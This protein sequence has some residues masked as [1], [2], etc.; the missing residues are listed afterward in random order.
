MAERRVYEINLVVRSPFLFQGTANSRFGVDAT[1]QRATGGSTPIIPATQIRGVLLAALS[2][3]QTDLLALLEKKTLRELFGASSETKAAEGHDL[4]VRGRIAFSDLQA[5]TTPTRSQI[6]RIALDEETGSVETGSLQVIELSH[7]LGM[8]CEFKGTFSIVWPADMPLPDISDIFTKALKLVPAIGALKSAGFGEV[9]VDRSVVR[10]LVERR[11]TLAI[12]A[13]A[14][15]ANPGRRRYRVRFDRPFVVDS[16][17][18]EENLFAGSPIVPGAVFKGALARRLEAMGHS[19][20][21][22]SGLGRAL[23]TAVFSH[24]FPSDTETR[25]TLGLPLPLSLV[26]DLGSGALADLLALEFGQCAPSASIT[27]FAKPAIKAEARKELALPALPAE[28]LAKTDR[29]HVKIDSTNLA[30]EEGKLFTLRMV[31]P[32][33]MLWEMTIDTGNVEDDAAAAL[34]HDAFKLGLDQI[35]RTEAS[36]AIEPAGTETSSASDTMFMLATPAVLFDGTVDLDVPMIER[37]RRY[38][39]AFL[40][41]AVLKNVFASRKLLGGYSATRF[42]SY[43]SAYYP[44][45]ATLPGSVFRLECPTREAA[46]ALNNAYRYG[47]PIPLLGGKKADWQTCPYVPENG[48]GAIVPHPARHLKPPSGMRVMETVDVR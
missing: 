6:T 40:G 15:A 22:S 12:V 46:E 33:G 31:D 48:Y 41:G 39:E 24:S 20:D 19:V 26:N 44:F 47:L 1:Y 25:R 17:R 32:G 38:F 37:Y 2:Q 21:A 18:A 43:G 29:T 5:A 27:A 30:A 8:D 36:V 10:E 4:P 14:G 3:N 13:P 28:K 34:I 11:K 9:V 7:P 16:M 45:V 42:R 23:S 35:G